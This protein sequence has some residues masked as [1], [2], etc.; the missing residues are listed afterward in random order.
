[1]MRAVCTRRPGHAFA[2]A[3]ALVASTSFERAAQADAQADFE[4]ARAAYR[5]HAYEDA[6]A[7]F[8][9]LLDPRAP[10]KLEPAVASQARMYLGATHI[11]EKRIQDAERVFEKLLVEDPRYDPDPLTFPTDVL[12]DFIDVRARIRQRLNDAAALAARLEAEKR[13]REELEKKHQAERL[14]ILEQMAAE[15]KITV[16]HSRLVASVPFG[17][18]QF[19]NGQNTLGWIFLGVE[20]ALVIGSGIA[21]IPYNDAINRRNEEHNAGD[22][23]HKENLYSN[24]AQTAQAVNLGIVGG[25]VLVMAGG[26]LQAHLA[27]VPEVPETKAR[28]I[29]QAK[30]SPSVTPWLTLGPDPNARSGHGNT[31]GSLGLRGTF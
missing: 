8:S 19:Q 16:R 14:H 18:G 21:F 26:V 15:E 6:E 2:L 5:A 30:A 9:A 22:P 4:K 10:E 12:N 27:F 11:A 25:L 13:A 1:M 24:R 31:S 20:S 3:L 28:P 7:R 29:P 17:A 23:D